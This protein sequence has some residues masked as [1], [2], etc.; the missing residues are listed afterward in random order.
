[1][2]TDI[3]LL[4]V[5]LLTLILTGLFAGSYLLTTR[6]K[7][8]DSA[9]RVLVNRWRLPRRVAQLRA[10]PRRLLYLTGALLCWSL[11]VT[12]I[13]AAVQVT[14]PRYAWIGT[15]LVVL[16]TLLELTWNDGAWRQSPLMAIAGLAA[17]VAGTA[18]N[19]VGL[20]V[21]M[22][23]DPVLGVDAQTATA[24]AIAV[25][26]LIELL[27]EPMWRIAW[28]LPGNPHR[29]PISVLIAALPGPAAR[30]LPP[31]IVGR[32]P[33]LPAPADPQ[34]QLG[35]LEDFED[36]PVEDRRSRGR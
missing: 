26:T 6:P 25:G 27:P 11:S 8:R 14:H 10:E 19:V 23:Y 9:W 12:L 35:L 28:S 1:M 29:D 33:S 16:V 4:L 2:T 34:P 30:H 36:D 22:Q 24:I 5:G 31:T 20:Y 13:T 21:L 32:Q 17:Y 18:T 7:L 15:G 3:T